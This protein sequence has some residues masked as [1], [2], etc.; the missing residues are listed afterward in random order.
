VRLCVKQNKT[1]ILKGIHD[2]NVS[3]NKEYNKKIEV[4]LKEPT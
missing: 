1:K 4:I 2:D 3:S